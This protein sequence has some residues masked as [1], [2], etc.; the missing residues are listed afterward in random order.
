MNK[1]KNSSL[2]TK[3]FLTFSTVLLAIICVICIMFYYSNVD[4]A[5]R[6][7]L[8]LSGIM[9]NQFSRTIDLYIKDIERLS[10]AI[11]TDPYIQETLTNYDETSPYADVSIRNNMYPRL[12]NLAYP[13]PEIEN[14]GLYTLNGKIFSYSKR[15]KVDV[16]QSLGNDRWLIE[17]DKHRKS[18]FLLLPT[19]PTVPSVINT[20][21]KE[22]VF[23]L[24]R[25]IYQIPQREKIGTLKIDINT[26]AME[27]I[28]V[29][30][31]EHELDQYV[32]VFVLTDDGH[33]IFD[34]QGEFTG[35]KNIGVEHVLQGPNRGGN[36][37]WQGQS[38]LYSYEKSSFTNWNTLIAIS[39]EFIIAEQRRIL[40]Y[41]F[42]SGLLA[43]IVI[44]LVSYFLSH[45][46]TKPIVNLITKMRLVE[47]GDLHERM[48]VTGNAEMDLLSRVYNNMLD[49]INRLIREVY[50]SKLTEKNA[51][52]AALQSQ[53]NPHFLYNTLNVMKSISRVK[54]VEEVAEI[55]ESLSDLF[56]YSMKHATEPV[57]LKDELDHVKNYMKIQYHRFGDR[58]V[59]QTDIEESTLHA[60]IPKL[61]IQPLIENAVNHGLG[62]VK[63]G[64]VISLKTYQVGDKL[65]IE[66]KDNGKGMVEETLEHI[67]KKVS[68]SVVMTSEENGIGLMNIEQRVQLLYG[69][70]NGLQFTSEVGEGTCVT[71]TVPFHKDKPKG[72]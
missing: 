58:F 55:S 59:L 3:M 2:K 66:V 61:S 48:T 68:L 23:S 44:A 46:I 51:K 25:N 38:Y 11:F 15:G 62:D 52:I 69:D 12:F 26:K 31:H 45:H 16:K 29:L 24:V 34:N 67:R 18:K 10:L 50:E 63:G 71:L 37:T 36:F 14:I 20:S 8:S 64:G 39:D 6:Q 17:L 13:R 43:I 42:V 47:Q 7:T 22:H 54:G 40:T 21:K 33:I 35:Y 41:I 57:L 32:R 28:V 1:W 27:E 56:K 72:G 70:S 19:I 5:E 30:Q 49:S 9:T 53:I 65:V 60:T 4:D